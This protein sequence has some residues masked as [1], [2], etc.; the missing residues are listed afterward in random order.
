MFSKKSRII[1]IFEIAKLL[2]IRNMNLKSASS[3]FLYLGVAIMMVSLIYMIIN[4]ANAD[5]FIGI[6][7]AFMM[8]GVSSTFW[9]IICSSTKKKNQAIE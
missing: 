1:H 7:I 9:G 4:L 3:F 8:A 2:N 6:W 5:S